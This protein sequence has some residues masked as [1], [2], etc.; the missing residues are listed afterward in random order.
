MLLPIYQNI[1]NLIVGFAMVRC[2]SIVK[3]YLRKRYQRVRFN[4]KLSNWGKINTGIWQGSILG[5]LLFLIYVNDLQSFIQSAAPSNIPV[6][7]FANDTSL[8]IN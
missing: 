5:L 6:V 1:A 7:L 4:D 3:S 8:I 2:P